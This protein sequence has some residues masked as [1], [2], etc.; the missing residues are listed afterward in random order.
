MI[1]EGGLLSHGFHQGQA[2]AGEGYLEGQAGE[3]GPGAHVYDAASFRYLLRQHQGHGEGVQEVSGLYLG[4]VD[5][6][7]EVYTLV[8]GGQ[9]F[10]V[11]VEVF[12]LVVGEV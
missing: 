4:V 10:I 7:G 8:P 3:A 9:L 11:T 6:A 5:N 12:K 2:Q 1:E